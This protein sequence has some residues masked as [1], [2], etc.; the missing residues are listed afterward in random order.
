MA[1]SVVLT[2]AVSAAVAAVVSALFKW[3]GQLAVRFR[4]WFRPDHAPLGAGE[5]PLYTSFDDRPK[6]RVLVACA[7]TR[8]VRKQEV[9]PDLAI[10]FA[11][12]RFGTHL[13]P[14]PTFS[15]PQTGVKFQEAGQATDMAYLWIWA[16]GRVDYSTFVETIPTESGGQALPLVEVVEPVVTVARAMA[17]REY[18]RLF[19]RRWAEL[20]RRFDW[21][22]AVGTHTKNDGDEAA[23]PWTELA[24]PGTSPPRAAG[25]QD[26]FCPPQ[27]YATEALRSWR[28]R[29]SVDELVAVFADSFLKQNG[30]NRCGPAIADVTRAVS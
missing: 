14:E 28:F 3:G 29:G 18:R 19:P 21:F 9:D 27:G 15:R 22:I 7:P 1:G 2:T 30:Y 13:A 8:S 26:P 24:F 5:W 16:V 12:R 10:G 20:P 25:E 6:I 4:A 11:C 17:S 23:K